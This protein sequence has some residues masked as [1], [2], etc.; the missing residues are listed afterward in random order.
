MPRFVC[1]RYRRS[2]PGAATGTV[3]D[4]WSFSAPDG[5]QAEA[6][7]RVLSAP[8]W[9]MDWETYFITLEDGKGQVLTT[10]HHSLLNA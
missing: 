8:M 2:A 1:K 10:W 4:E 5:A 3:M 7:I 9:G 6:R